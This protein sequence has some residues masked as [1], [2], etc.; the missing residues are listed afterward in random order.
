[1]IKIEYILFFLTGS[2]VGHLLTN[3]YHEEPAAIKSSPAI[4]IEVQQDCYFTIEGEDHK[5][6]FLTVDDI[7]GMIK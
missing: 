7:E 3:L 5:L 4:T 6:K 2:F 1:M